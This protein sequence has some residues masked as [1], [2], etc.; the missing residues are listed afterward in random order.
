MSIGYI[1]LLSFIQGL[2][3]FIPVSSSAHLLI[4]P[5][6][7]NYEDQGVFFDVVA[8]LGSLFAVLYFYRNDFI[9]LVR[10][11]FKKGGNRK[12]SFNIIVSMIPITVLGL[13]FVVFNINL[14]NP[15]IVVFTSIIFGI[16]LYLSDKFGKNVKNI[17]SL[18]YKEAFFI[19]VMQMMA[20]VPGVSRSGATVSGGLFLGM[21]RRD[22]LK[23]SFLLSVPTIMMVG[24][25]SS[26]KLAKSGV[27]FSYLYPSLFMFFGSFV[28]SMFTIKF[29]M[30][31]IKKHSFKWFAIYRVLLGIVLYLFLVLHK[32]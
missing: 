15:Y 10:E 22:A 31:F 28:F 13:G 30:K 8:H 4:L 5:Y 17:D 24:L 29:M 32:V 27:D 20:V 16:V 26:L 21:K 12:L 1:L 9:L 18:S 6:L 19:G 11:F 3:E 2:T 7:M 14:R 23:F 25:G